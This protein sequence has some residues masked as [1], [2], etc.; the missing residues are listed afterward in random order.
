[1]KRLS[2]EMALKRDSAPIMPID[3]F[4]SLMAGI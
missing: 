4:D 2:L 3:R 1:M